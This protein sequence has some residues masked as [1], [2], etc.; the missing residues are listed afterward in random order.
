MLVHLILSQRSLH[1][2]LFLFILFSLFCS[3]LFL[4]FYL[5]TH[6]SIL[7]MC[8]SFWQLCCSSLIV[9]L[10][11]S[12]SA[13]AAKSPQSCPPLCDPIDGSPPGSPVPEIL[14]A[15]TLEWVAISFSNAW[16]WKWSRSIMSDSSR[17]WLNIYFTFSIHACT[18][19]LRS[20]IL[21]TIITLKSFLG[22]LPIWSSFIS[23]CGYLACSFFCNIFLSCLV[24][25]D[26][27]C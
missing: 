23:P 20:W 10:F 6:L 25:S 12:S 3:A 14:Q 21:F 26:L 11:T 18:L 19:C 22:R 9:V 5:L 2:S 24:L 16:K 8:F 13:V 15:R 17:S 4:P 27:L 1:L 7:L